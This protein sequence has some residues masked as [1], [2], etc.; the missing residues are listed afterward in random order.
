MLD[1]DTYVLMNATLTIQD[2]AFRPFGACAAGDF[3][4]SNSATVPLDGNRGEPSCLRLATVG[5]KQFDHAHGMRSFVARE[6]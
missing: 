6:G 5:R 4:V 2:L 1:R 3:E